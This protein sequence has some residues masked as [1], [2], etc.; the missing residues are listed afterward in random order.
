M[1]DKCETCNCEETVEHVLVD[2]RKFSVERFKHSVVDM[3]RE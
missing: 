2:S 1:S 3:G